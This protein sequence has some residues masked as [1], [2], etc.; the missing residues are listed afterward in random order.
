MIAE[1]EEDGK[2]WKEAVTAQ[3]GYCS[4]LL[5]QSLVWALLTIHRR[6]PKFSSF[7]VLLAAA[8]FFVN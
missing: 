1:E 7:T 2:K 3:D 5:L 8:R 6:M 4:S